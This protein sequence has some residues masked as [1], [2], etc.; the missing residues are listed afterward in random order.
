MSTV[1]QALGGSEIEVAAK[2]TRRQF[3]SNR[4]GQDPSFNR[5]SRVSLVKTCNARNAVA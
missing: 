4:E 2:A 3:T 5:K 1:E